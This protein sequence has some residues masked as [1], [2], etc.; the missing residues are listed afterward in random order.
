[1]ILLGVSA[2]A[3]ATSTVYK[4]GIVP[5]FD[6][7]HT[8]AIWRPLLAEI[9][10]RTGLKLE[11]VASENFPSFEKDLAAAHF[12]FAYMNPF[13]FLLA[14][15]NQSY[16]PLV[17][18]GAAKVQGIL[19]VRKDSRVQKPE[20]LAGQTIAF[21][22][23]NAVAASMLIRAGLERDFKIAYTPNFLANHT[24]AYEAVVAGSA[25]AAGGARA[26]LAEQPEAIRNQLRVVFET[27]SFA[28]L[29]FTGHVRVPAAER[30]KVKQ[31]FLAIEADPAAQ[32]MLRSVPIKEAVS[33]AMSDYRQL[34]HWGLER[35]YVPPK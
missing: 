28:S 4:V 32:A 17:R 24:A 13:Q 14:R 35:Y 12:D 1:M 21:P 30:E 2:D 15:R 25:A 8:E 29:P 19:V 18:D 26:T 33:A 6:V 3:P 23:A 7:A 5:Q 16:E 9:G 22:G 34:A 10:K 11:V 31:A 20:E 27:A